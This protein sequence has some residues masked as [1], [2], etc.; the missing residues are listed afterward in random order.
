M[1]TDEA[2]L[3]SAFERLVAA[4][5]GKP[6][7]LLHLAASAMRQ[8]KHE[9]GLELAIA[10]RELAGE[11]RNLA[12]WA[13]DMIA[14][15]VFK[16]HVPMIRDDPRNRAFEAAILRAITPETRLLDIGSG[17]GLLAMMAARAGARQVYSCEANVALAHVAREIVEKNG[18]ADRV[19]I[20]AKH[21]KDV[22]A[23]ADLGGPA[24]L[25]V[26][27]LVGNDLVNE[28]ILPS[29]RDVVHRLIRPGAQ[30]IPR[31][32]EI[33]VALAWWDG[34]DERRMGEECGFD[35]AP[36]NP[37]L[38]TRFGIEVGDDKLVLRGE[39]ASLFAFD[40]AATAPPPETAEIALLA[41][42]G[43][44]NG[45]AQ[46]IR[47]HMDE[48]GQYENRPETGTSSHWSCLFF[49]LKRAID[50]ALCPVVRIGGTHLGNRL[51][52]WQA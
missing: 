35:M 36:F 16:Y 34:L 37:L 3:D 4:A 12:S 27:E 31:A 18:Y 25:C 33:R 29:M 51:R 19:T 17:T 13:S 1:I 44:I 6:R 43:P 24:D 21:S 52:L 20:L 41:H 10:A 46:W 42:S 47:L 28:F 22:D 40:F 9:R 48:V 5:A 50:G 11:D 23:D 15:S 45:I 38:P 32:G 2:L 7:A 39:E 8:G 14:G 26:A 49:P 30:V